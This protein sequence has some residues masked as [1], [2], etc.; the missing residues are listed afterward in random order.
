MNPNTRSNKVEII[1]L[2]IYIFSSMLIFS[3][4]INLLAILVIT[5]YKELIGATIEIVPTVRANE[6]KIFPIG[7][8]PH[9]LIISSL[10]SSTFLG[11]TIT[12]KQKNKL[13]NRYTNPL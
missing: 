6:Y 1:I 4:N 5:E 10:G 2:K 12:I 8:T 11:E 7:V 3:F 9:P 13:T